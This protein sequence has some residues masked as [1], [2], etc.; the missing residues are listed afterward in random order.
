MRMTVAD[1]VTLSS[2]I[3]FAQLAAN[4]QTIPAASLNGDVTLNLT[5][6]FTTLT[7]TLYYRLTLASTDVLKT[8]EVNEIEFLK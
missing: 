8:P 2:P 6:L 4:F 5:S 3:W 1:S 7:T